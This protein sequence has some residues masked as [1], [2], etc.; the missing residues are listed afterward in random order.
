MPGSGSPRSGVTSLEKKSLWFGRLAGDAYVEIDRSLGLPR[1]TP[2]LVLQ[3]LEAREGGM[4][5]L[6][7]M[8]W[9]RAWAQALPEPPAAI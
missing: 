6:D 8:A 4:G 7:W 3:A 2:A 9:L 1:L 5:M